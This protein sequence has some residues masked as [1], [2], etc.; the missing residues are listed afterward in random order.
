MSKLSEKRRKSILR[1]RSKFGS[2]VRFEV[3]F[4]KTNACFYF[5]LNDLLDRKTVFSSSTKLFKMDNP[6]KNLKSIKFATMLSNVLYDYCLKN[7]ITQNIA[8]NVA[9]YKFHGL[10]KAFSDNLFKKISEL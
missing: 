6:L 3:L 2:S 10:I 5:Q 8:V 9:N 4:L 7:N 1:I